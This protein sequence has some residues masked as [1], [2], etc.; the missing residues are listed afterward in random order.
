MSNFKHWL[1]AWS[2]PLAGI[3][4]YSS[5]LALS[6]L[7]DDGEGMLVVAN[8]DNELKI[9]NNVSVLTKTR[10]SSRPVGTVVFNMIQSGQ[11][12][13]CICTASGPYLHIYK[14]VDDTLKKVHRFQLPALPIDPDE[15]RLWNQVFNESCNILR[16]S[17]GLTQLQTAQRRLTEFSSTFLLFPEKYRESYIQIT[18]KKAMNGFNQSSVVTC[19]TTI[20]KLSQDAGSPSCIVVGDEF[21]NVHILD[22]QVLTIETTITMPNESAISHI[23]AFGVLDKEYRL[24]VCTRAGQIY[25]VKDGRL[26]QA[27]IEVEAPPI[28]T[29]LI[30]THIFIACMN[31]MM[32]ITDQRGRSPRQIQMPDFIVGIQP[33]FFSTGTAFKGAII[34][35]ANGTVRVYSSRGPVVSEFSINERITGFRFGVYGRE[36]GACVVI[37]RSA[38]LHIKMLS[39][40]ANLSADIGIRPAQ[41]A[42]MSKP[43]PIPSK[44]QLFLELAEAEKQNAPSIHR[45]FQK[46]LSQMRLTTSKEFLK[47]LQHGHAPIAAGNADIQLRLRSKL[48][49]IGPRYT[50]K[51]TVENTGEKPVYSLPLVIHFNPSIYWFKPCSSI[52]GA[53]P[54]KSEVTKEFLIGRTNDGVDMEEPSR[55]VVYDEKGSKPIVSAITLIP[56]SDF[57]ED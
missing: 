13:K 33:V 20:R 40:L 16:L 15:E 19:L 32:I 38:A 4:A 47:L 27:R 8:L 11:P 18:G 48:Q 3:E 1:D 12:T 41:T 24:V 52:I 23:S 31:K 26:T 29:A 36:D 5:H 50:L 22:E 42:E 17:D 7:H 30:G 6:D 10:L 56:I 57:V 43:L 54:P 51:V 25:I 53:L 14:L 2:D 39:R 35:L 46:E 34:G 45:A 55:I 44:S 28:G 37:G 21:G 9:F 49:G